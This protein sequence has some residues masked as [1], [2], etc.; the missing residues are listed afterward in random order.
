MLI[1]LGEAQHFLLQAKM[2]ADHGQL[3]K[4]ELQIY[5]ARAF[6]LFLVF[7][8]YLFRRDRENLFTWRNRDDCRDKLNNEVSLIAALDRRRGDVSA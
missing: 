8:I 2:N 1:L 7:S 5:P 6:T 3:Q 4:G